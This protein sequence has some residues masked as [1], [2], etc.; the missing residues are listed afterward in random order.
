MWQFWSYR[1][2][3]LERPFLPTTIAETMTLSLKLYTK[4]RYRVV[5]KPFVFTHS[6]GRL[7]VGAR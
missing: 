3:S 6:L 1:D 5:S 2:P 4:R 7:Y